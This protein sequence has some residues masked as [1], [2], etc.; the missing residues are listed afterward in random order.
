MCLHLELPELLPSHVCEERSSVFGLWKPAAGSNP[1]TV[2]VFMLLMASDQR[3]ELRRST[4]CCRLTH[5]CVCL[6]FLLRRSLRHFRGS[7]CFEGPGH[8]LPGEGRPEGRVRR[9][10]RP[11]R[12][13]DGEREGVGDAVPGCVSPQHPRIS[14]P[15]LSLLADTRE[16]HSC[17]FYS[18]LP[19]PQGSSH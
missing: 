9:P 13:P 19:P 4:S 6:F 8:V 12:R 17:L 15:P 1:S 11:Q 2:S 3:V 18:A 7:G 14:V 10:V 16:T 5:G